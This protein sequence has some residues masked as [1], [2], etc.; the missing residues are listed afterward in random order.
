MAIGAEE[1]TLHHHDT[2]YN[3]ERARVV[4]GMKDAAWHSVIQ[5]LISPKPEFTRLRGGYE[6]VPALQVG[7]DVYCDSKLVMAEIERRVPEP[8]AFGG[9]DFIV[10]ARV[11]RFFTPAT[12]AVGI[13]HM[14]EHV[15]PEF[16]RDRQEIYGPSFDLEAMKAA[17][18]I[19]AGQ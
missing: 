6:R 17:S 3:S 1:L 7:A 14:S 16:L 15:A 5:P 19:M 9:L 8:S 10:A 18:G 11:D 13:P 2:S 12:F 4:L